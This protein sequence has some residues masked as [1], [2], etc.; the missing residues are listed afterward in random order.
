MK[1]NA[2]IL[3]LI[4]LLLLFTATHCSNPP[5]FAAIEQEVTLK[6]ASVKGI[7]RGIA[8]IQNTVYVTNGQL[9]SKKI[10]DTGSWNSIAVP[11][12][13]DSIATDG[14]T[15]YAAIDGTGYI[16]S[17][18]TWQPIA[19]KN[20]A[21]VT[22]S[23]TVFATDGK[24]LYTVS[25]TAASEI[26][27]KKGILQ[28]AAGD[29]C[30][31]TT[32]IYNASGAQIGGPTSELKAI[33]K[34]PE[35]GIFVLAGAMLY[36]YNGS[37]TQ[38]THTVS[39][40][41]SLTYLAQKQLVLI[42]GK[43]GFAEIKLTTAE[44]NVHNAQAVKVGSA[45]SSIAPEHYHQYKNSVGKWNINPIAAFSHQSGYTLYAGVLDGQNPKHTGLWGFYHSSQ[46]EWNRE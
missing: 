30:M 36:A 20:L 11:A 39:E 31:T 8:Q 1:K 5:I 25:G 46:L 15:L 40:P 32:G 41:Q 24:K 29:Y 44:A 18:S 37:W 9:F 26:G 45:E 4:M 23:G 42:S 38:C 7:I 16:L 19:T 43:E 17:G 12:S 22:G 33:C 2:R 21:F 6:T 10:G 28:G 14:G 13:C 27:V 34:G 3:T 35:E